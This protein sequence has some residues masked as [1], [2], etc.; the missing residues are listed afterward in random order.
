LPFD[1]LVIAVG[2]ETNFFG[3]DSVAE[4]GFGLKDLSDATAIRN[5][6]LQLFETAVYESDPEKCRALL[7]FVIVGG[8]PT[9]V[10]CAGALSELIRLV[11]RKDYP[12]LDIDDVRIILLEALDNLLIS[13]PEE[14][15]QATTR[16]L[17]RKQVEVRFHSTVAN[18]DGQMVQ[19][20]DG[21]EIQ[22]HTLIWSAGVRAS[23]L[24]DDLSLEQDRAGRIKVTPS[25]QVPGFEN[26]FVIGD[27]AH[28]LDE[29]GKPL[30]MI[31][32]V[33]IQQ[34]PLAAKNIIHLLDGKPLQTFRYRDPGI[35]ATIGRN[36]AV[37]HVW[38]LKI[39]GFP[40]W[41]MWVVVHI[42]QL[43]GFRNRLAVL[44]DWAWSYLFYDRAS[45]IIGPT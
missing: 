45:R 33:A 15:G 29:S 36:Q 16:V 44:L 24:L 14:L 34:A 8:G 39:R 12:T 4:H 18:Y 2:G 6:L 41:V 19:L 35:M 20:K 26:V 30:P 22:S 7:T 43:I 37:A 17:E 42:L 9:G 11:L 27:A 23:R 21:T 31:A 3:L 25:L 38:G 10:E 32:P 40:A 5:H 28:L 13:M 1:Y